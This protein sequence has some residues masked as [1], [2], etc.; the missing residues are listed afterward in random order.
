VEGLLLSRAHCVAAAVAVA[1][2]IA[3][4]GTASAE[5]EDIGRPATAFPDDGVARCPG[6]FH[7]GDGFGTSRGDLTSLS[8]GGKVVSSP[9]SDNEGQNGGPGFRSEAQRG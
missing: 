6:L 8:V 5:V 4:S 7:D 3:G 9:G 2:L 1:F